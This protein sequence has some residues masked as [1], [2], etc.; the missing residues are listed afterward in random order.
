MNFEQKLAQTIINNIETYESMVEFL[1]EKGDQESARRW[2]R[3]KRELENLATQMWGE[4]ILGQFN[5]EFI[6]NLEKIVNNPSES[7]KHQIMD[8][9]QSGIEFKRNME[10]TIGEE[11]E[12]Y[13]KSLV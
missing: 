9:F 6:K 4:D 5:L 11:A 12:N 10:I 3:K 8:A 13:Y 1:T 2:R 7:F